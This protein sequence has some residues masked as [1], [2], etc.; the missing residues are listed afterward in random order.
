MLS[1]R[2]RPA[3]V[4]LAALLTLGTAGPAA[5]AE[6]LDIGGKYGTID[7][8]IGNSKVFRTTGSFKDWHGTVT[9]DDV[10]VTHSSV[11]VVV[12]TTSIEMLDVQQTNMLKDSEYFDV[13]HFPEMVFHSTHVERTGD[14]ALQVDGNI[15]LRGITRPM[16]LAVTVSDRQPKAVPGTRYAQFRGVGTIR[17]SEFGMTKYV[18]MMGDK[19]EISITT[20]A[21]RR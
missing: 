21:R 12:K 6:Q 18:D 1:T 10:D 20:E 19:V 17:R 3:A 13:A 2:R 8:A 5:A 4:L 11:D 9:V 7:F 14:N 16:T 15:T